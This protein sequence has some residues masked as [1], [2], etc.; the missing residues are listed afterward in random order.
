MKL[1][2]TIPISCTGTL[3]TRSKSWHRRWWP[4]LAARSRALPLDV[5]ERAAPVLK[6]SRGCD[7]NPHNERCR[8]KIQHYIHGES[9]HD[10]GKH[11]VRSVDQGVIDNVLCR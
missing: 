2:Q 5:G 1:V 9:D 3:R 4:N 7:H 6:K 8:A 11:A 10:I